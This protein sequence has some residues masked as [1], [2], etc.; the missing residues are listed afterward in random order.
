MEIGCQ[1]RSPSDGTIGHAPTFREL[2]V[3][4]VDAEELY[5]EEGVFLLPLKVGA[6]SLQLAACVQADFNGIVGLVVA[7]PLVGT[8]LDRS[9]GERG[10]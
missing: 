6:A 8:M 5:V 7:V 2:S 10:R 9:L 3:E 1:D 4:I